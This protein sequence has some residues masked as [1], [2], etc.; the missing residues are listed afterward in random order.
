MNGEMAILSF[1]V[2]ICHAC[3][4][5]RGAKWAPGYANESV[6]IDV[7]LLNNQNISFG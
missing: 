2:Q 1:F 4:G 6:R 3:L 5:K 7:L